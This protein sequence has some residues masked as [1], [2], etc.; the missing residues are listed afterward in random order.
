MKSSFF[1]LLVLSTSAFA[2][3]FDDNPGRDKRIQTLINSS[4]V[5]KC[6]DGSAKVYQDMGYIRGNFDRAYIAKS[7]ENVFLTITPRPEG[8][9]VDLYY[10][11]VK[12]VYFQN[13]QQK[14]VNVPLAFYSY[15]LGQ[16]RNSDNCDFSD[17]LNGSVDLTFQGSGTFRVQLRPVMA[18][19]AEM[20]E[21]K[22]LCVQGEQS[23]R[24]QDVV[25]ETGDE[26]PTSVLTE[27]ISSTLKK[28]YSCDMR[29]LISG[30][31]LIGGA[32]SIKID[33]INKK[34]QL[35]T[36][37]SFPGAKEQL[38]SE[39]KLQQGTSRYELSDRRGNQSFELLDTNTGILTQSFVANGQ[40]RTQTFR[41]NL[42]NK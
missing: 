21:Y 2:Q 13:G 33:D 37:G 17:I 7:N 24:V 10:C 40:N 30:Q 28:K 29:D 5:S 6:A 4:K 3:T 34:A 32:Y 14:K 19:A 25:C 1:L 39:L 20:A 12:S 18:S 38:D 35:L 27:Q 11:P 16:L 8:N 23:A 31:M 41:C 26:T 9:K 15:N 36:I 22:K 42:T